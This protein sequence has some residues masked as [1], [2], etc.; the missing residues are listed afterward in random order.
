MEGMEASAEDKAR[1]NKDVQTNLCY[2]AMLCL[3][4]RFG[5]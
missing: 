4:I 1:V 2:F 3:T 5:V